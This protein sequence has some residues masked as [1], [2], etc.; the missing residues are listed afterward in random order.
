[1]AEPTDR[2]CPK[3]GARITVERVDHHF[4]GDERLICPQH[5]IVGYLDDRRGG[6]YS[7]HQDTMDDNDD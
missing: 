6:V 1:M 2:R 3:C 5:G 7:R 4:S